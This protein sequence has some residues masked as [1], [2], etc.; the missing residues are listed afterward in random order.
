MRSMSIG[1]LMECNLLL[2]VLAANLIRLRFA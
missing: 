2:A 1:L